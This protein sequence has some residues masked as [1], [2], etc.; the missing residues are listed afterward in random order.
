VDERTELTHGAANGRLTADETLTAL[1]ALTDDGLV[2][3]DGEDI[4]RRHLSR[5]DGYLFPSERS[6]TGHVDG[7]TIAGWFHVLVD[8]AGVPEE[9]DGVALKPHM[10]RRFWYDAY[11]RTIEDLL[12]Y[13]DDIAAE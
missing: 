11:S 3:E 1:V 5:V 10:G 12:A 7:T 4:A 6:K 8:K 13:V 2:E 9:I